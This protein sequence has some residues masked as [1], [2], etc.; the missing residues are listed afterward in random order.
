M[1]KNQTDYR[2]GMKYKA[3]SKIDSEDSDKHKNIGTLRQFQRDIP[4]H[5]SVCVGQNLG[6]LT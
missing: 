5:Y 1:P 6:E 4:F 2:M 3:M